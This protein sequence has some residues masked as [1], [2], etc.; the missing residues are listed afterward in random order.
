MTLAEFRHLL[1]D[2]GVMLLLDALVQSGLC[3]SKSDARRK[4]REGAIRVDNWRVENEMTYIC[5]LG[6]GS[7]CLV[8]FI[9]NND[10]VLD[11]KTNPLRVKICL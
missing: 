10:V 11:I 7:V 2:A 3:K 9:D 1:A 6:D 5:N 8:E 4:V